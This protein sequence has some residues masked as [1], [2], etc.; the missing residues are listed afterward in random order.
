MATA[1]S[2]RAVGEESREDWKGL[3]KVYEARRSWP[4]ACSGAVLAHA[5]RARKRRLTRDAEKISLK[6]CSAAERL[7]FWF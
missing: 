2:I 4:E 3:L 7:K 6:L 5:M 1:C